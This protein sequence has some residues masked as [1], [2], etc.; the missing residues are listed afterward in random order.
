VDELPDLTLPLAYKHDEGDHP[1][2]GYCADLLGEDDLARW[3][4]I[5]LQ[6]Q[7]AFA[8]LAVKARSSLM[9]SGTGYEITRPLLF[10][11]HHVCEVAIKV[12]LVAAWADQTDES[13][14]S[15]SLLVRLWGRFDLS[16]RRAA[17]G[18]ESGIRGHDLSSL[19]K[20]L[21]K[22]NGAHDL[23]DDQ[24]AWCREFTRQMSRLT[25]QGFEGRYADER[26]TEEAW[27]CLHLDQ[28][29]S[30]VAAL[31]R[32]MLIATE[33][34]LEQSEEGARSITPPGSRSNS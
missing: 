10:M 9:E 21:V 19:W 28:L 6:Q 25:R 31:V 17:S 23:T 29:E 2:G 13:A 34:A 1:G 24:I 8:N 12:G 4:E 14:R 16:G 32:L 15:S 3:S 22:A 26:R 18:S 5:L 11:A 27:C 7:A 30:C 33:K 20:R